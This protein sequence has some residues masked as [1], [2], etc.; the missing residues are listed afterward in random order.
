VVAALVVVLTD[1]AVPFNLTFISLLK[2]LYVKAY[3][4]VKR[5]YSHPFTY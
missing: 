1:I 2:S 4:Y 3:T 5:K